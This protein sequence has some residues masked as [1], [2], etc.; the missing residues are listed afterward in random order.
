MHHRPLSECL[1]PSFSVPVMTR[2]R[3][4]CHPLDSGGWAQ[5]FCQSVGFT[6]TILVSHLRFYE[7][8]GCVCSEEQGRVSIPSIS[9]ILLDWLTLQTSHRTVPCEGKASLL[10]PLPLPLPLPKQKGRAQLSM[11]SNCSAG[12]QCSQGDLPLTSIHG[13]PTE[14]RQYSGC[15]RKSCGQPW[16]I[17]ACM[18]RAELPS[19]K[20]DTRQGANIMHCYT[21]DVL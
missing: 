17:I 21:S 8:R 11:F 20:K 2:T 3:C 6:N 7:H 18:C 16:C 10:N 13:A 14:C 5:K 1:V 15:L 4:Y 9:S 19:G 12:G